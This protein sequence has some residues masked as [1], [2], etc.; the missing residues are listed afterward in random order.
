MFLGAGFEVS[1]GLLQFQVSSL[2]FRFEDQ[3]VCELSAAA[4]A[5]FC[6]LPPLCHHGL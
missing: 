5:A 4:P 3:D 6:L 2:C 1:K